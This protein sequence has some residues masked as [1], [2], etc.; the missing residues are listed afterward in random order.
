MNRTSPHFRELVQQISSAGR[1]SETVC[2]VGEIGTGKRQAAVTIHRASTHLQGRFITI[3]CMGLSDEE[4]A[5]DLFGR[6]S[7]DGELVRKGA[8]NLA[9]GGTLYLHEVCELSKRSQAVLVRFLETDTYRPIGSMSTF[10]SNLRVIVSSSM[11]MENAV[12]TATLRNDLYHLLTPVVIHLPRLNDRLEDIPFLF[13]QVLGE[14]ASQYD[15]PVDDAAF[16]LLQN[17]SFNGNLLELRNIAT[18]IVSKTPEG[19][20]TAEIMSRALRGTNYT[21]TAAHSFRSAPEIV[22]NTYR[23][24]DSEVKQISG[25]PTLSQD[26]TPNDTDE[27][28]EPQFS[29]LNSAK[30]M[31]E[32]GEESSD[33]Q[34]PESAPD[35]GDRA[36][37]VDPD[38]SDSQSTSTEIN[39]AETGNT[40]PKERPLLTLKEQEAVYLQSLLDEFDNDKAKVAEVAGLA[41]RTLYRRL[42]DL[43]IKY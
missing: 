29:A 41:V 36:L 28:F 15:R 2:L 43:G 33:L 7:D 42:K 5:I 12:E 26:D 13:R 3:N 38:T 34:I 20:I 40:Q 14:I 24:L 9:E 27:P 11:S 19:P 10:S 31:S 23:Q 1:S 32:L 39:G 35:Y 8:A 18:R 17:H 16:E 4:F 37:K 22:Q 6:M 25:T 21:E 30:R